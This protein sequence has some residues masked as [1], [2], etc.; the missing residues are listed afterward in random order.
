M[1]RMGRI[2]PVYLLILTFVVALLGISAI[3]AWRASKPASGGP[4]PAIRPDLAG[5]V[6]INLEAGELMGSGGPADLRA[7]ADELLS[8]LEKAGIRWVRFTLPWDE[9]EPSDGQYDWAGWDQVMAVLAQHPAIQPLVVLDRTP[10]WARPQVDAG[11]PQAPPH[12]RSDFG[13]FAASVAKRYGSQIRYYQVWNEPNIAPHW[14]A[15]PVDPAG[16][17]GLLREGT[18]SIRAA[19]PDSLIVLGALAPTIET[20]GANLSDI[21]F[22]DAIYAAGARNWFDIAA[23][24][25]YGFSDPASAPSDPQRLNFARVELL[26]QVMGR[27]GDAAKPIWAT[28]A[29]WNSLPPGWTGQPSPWGQV[30]DEAQS[31]NAAEALDTAATRW[32]WLGALFW[33]SHCPARPAG[34][35]W[36]GFS[37]CAPGGELRPVWQALA[38]A[39]AKPAILPPGDHATDHPA[40]HYGPGW[41]ISPQGADPHADGDELAFEFYGSEL[42]LRVQGG[43]YWAY[44]RMSVDGR[45]ANALPRDESGAAYLVLN[46]P[47]A[48]T[49]VVKVADALPLGR[50]QVRLKA[51]GGWGQW[52]LQGILVSATPSPRVDWRILALMAVLAVALWVTLAWPYRQEA[53][54]GVGELLIR[55]QLPDSA[56]WIATF[57]LGLGL[58]FSHRAPVDLALLAG[59][60]LVFFLRPDLSL[61][62]VAASIPWW[63]APKSLLG[64][65]FSLYEIFISL[66][67]AA[68]VARWALRRWG[69]SQALLEEGAESGGRTQQ[70]DRRGVLGLTGA[71]AGLDWPVVALLGVGLAS[72]IAA[73]RPGVALREWR[74][75]F[76]DG[77]LFYWLITRTRWPEGRRFSPWGLVNGLL[78]GIAAVSVL[79]LWQLATG[80]GRIDVEGVWRVRALYGSPNNLALVLDRALPLA[81]ALALFGTWRILG[82]AGSR[83]EPG[84]L[85]SGSERD[86]TLLL[87]IAYTLAT[88]VMGLACVA[89]FS[90]GAILLGLPAGVGVV[91]LLGAWR[92][93][94]SRPMWALAGLAVLGVVALVLLFRT[95]RFADLLNFQAGTS[96]FRVKL[97]QAAWRMGFDHPLLGVG[98]DNF[99]YAYR[100]AYVLPGAWQELNLSHPHNLLLDLWTRLGIFGVLAG[101]WAWI[102]TVG[103][104]WRLFGSRLPED[105]RRNGELWPLVL[106]LLGG[107]AAAL[108]HGLIDNSLFLVDLMALFMLAAGLLERLSRQA[109]PLSD[110][111]AFR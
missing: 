66:A 9:I 16:Y 96:F 42:A 17:V 84:G 40:L 15:R 85:T 90:K 83:R 76:L 108:I 81:L 27:A 91:I 59:L 78:A 94:R 67:I 93:R 41:R 23:A 51:V 19:D 53:A 73:Q 25:P 30:S 28:S 11:N 5:A 61:P 49:R 7:H 65:E 97:W 44:D 14:G 79:G 48:E 71:L 89:T 82:P 46:D 12:E 1:R 60:A 38:S 22:L 106:G 105:I 75:V 8:Q 3:V 57:V 24:E 99:L 39:A 72:T 92:V 102:A 4:V 77:A 68:S 100:S 47:L 52:A 43:P 110:E 10:A 18:A 29:G 104:G 111:A 101:G 103:L 35:P 26:R 58:A 21:S 109:G 63:P 36:Q 70:P 31:S 56:L 2:R 88:L 98:P 33:A 20:G 64:R 13:T 62:L 95:R 54:D 80:Q 69:T 107:L 6:G 37:V 45:P 74:I 87:R 86:L 50:H 55:A 34:D 32:P